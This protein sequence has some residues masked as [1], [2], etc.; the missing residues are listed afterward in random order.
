MRVIRVYLPVDLNISDEKI[1]D[2]LEDFD[3]RQLPEDSNFDHRRQRRE[4]RQISLSPLGQ[5]ELA[6]QPSR[7]AN[8]GNLLQSPFGLL[9]A[10][11]REGRGQGG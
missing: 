11:L 3:Y 5:A 1:A 8:A 9:L 6:D 2:L 7:G 10:P 4:V